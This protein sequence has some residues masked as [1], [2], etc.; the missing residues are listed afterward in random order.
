ML[1]ALKT[2][3]VEIYE[4][5]DLKEIEIMGCGGIMPQKNQACMSVMQERLRGF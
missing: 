4:N 5:W 1:K 2:L 3:G